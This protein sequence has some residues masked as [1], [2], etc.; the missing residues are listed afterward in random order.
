METNKND[1]TMVH[2]LWDAVK[3][4]LRGIYS[5]KGLPQEIRKI[6]NKQSNLTS[7]DLR[8]KKQKTKQNKKTMPKS[9]E[10]KI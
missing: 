4:V 3:A 10:E 7:K 2:N 1:N 5:D 6:S 9:V 8:V